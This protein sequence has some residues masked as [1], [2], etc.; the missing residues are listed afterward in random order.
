MKGRVKWVDIAKGIA[1]S[2]VVYGHFGTS[3]A[4]KS[5]IYAFHIPL[6]F[7]LSGLFFS[8]DKFPNYT[9]F[10]RKR[11]FQLLIPYLFFNFITYL[12]WLFIGRKFGNDISTNVNALKP[13]FG[14]VYGNASNLAHNVPLWFL[15]CLF[16]VENFYFLIF[17][18]TKKQ[19]Q[20]FLLVMIAVI[21]FINYKFNHVFRL[22]WGMDIAMSMLLFY[23][24]GVS[25]KSEFLDKNRSKALLSALSIM[26]F[27]VVLIIAQLNGKIEVSDNYFGN[28]LYFLLGAS[29]GIIF[30]V[31]LSMLITQVKI[32]YSLLSFL[33]FNSLI[34]FVLHLYSGSFIKAISFFVFHLPLSIYETPSV[35]LLLTFLSILVLIPVVLL[36]NK[37][38]PFVVGKSK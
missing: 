38:L 33:G 14:I 19:Q 35:S 6:F 12:F 7:F 22:P 27:L 37:F 34:I 13:I 36:M 11:S 23:G 29:A 28:Y 10:L 2:L 32:R 16:S 15:T 26:S 24:L 25:L 4:A 9:S 3:D 21:A 31:S 20:F 1:V 8:F 18:K 5:V 30:I 17:R